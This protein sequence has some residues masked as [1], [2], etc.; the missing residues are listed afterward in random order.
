M[1]I[2]C[3]AMLVGM[4]APT[5]PAGSVT[6]AAP[7]CR[8]S[9]QPLLTLPGRVDTLLVPDAG[10]T[11][12]AL[13]GRA[14]SHIRF[15]PHDTIDLIDADS[16]SPTV[17]S[18]PIPLYIAAPGTAASRDGRRLYALVDATLLTF[19]GTGTRLIAKQ[20]LSLQAIGWPAAITTGPEGEIYLVGQPSGAMETQAYAF[21]PDA[22]GVL[23]LSWRSPLGLTHAGTWIGLAG[24][25][26]LA[27]YVPDQ[28][29]TR[30]VM[31]LLDAI[32]GAM[33]ASYKIPIPP[34][35]AAAAVDRLYLAGAGTVRGIVLRT[36]KPV[37][38]VRGDTPL[39][40]GSS[41]GLVAFVRGNRLVVAHGGDLRTA[42]TLPFPDAL[43]PTA[44]AWQRAALLVGNAR[45]IARLEL[46]GCP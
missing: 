8:P 45:G 41:S 29:D 27:V 3:L 22:H 2:A 4:L 7:A 23:R 10:R 19:D 35:A 12:L 15:L 1:R 9:V 31:A 16:P 30:G 43:P 5:A 20:N 21:R 40:A 17:R 11:I 34:V 36:G 28:S 37:A 39:A 6:R 33:R 18:I 46:T 42:M 14:G 24:D 32:R 25:G 44:L 26:E 13:V 38:A